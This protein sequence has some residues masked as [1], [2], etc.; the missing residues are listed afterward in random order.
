MKANL[1]NAKLLFVHLGCLYGLGIPIIIVSI[2]MSAWLAINLWDGNWIW[3]LPVLIIISIVFYTSLMIL[4]TYCSK[5]WQSRRPISHKIL[6]WGCIGFMYLASIGLSIVLSTQSIISIFL[7]KSGEID[8][9][10]AQGLIIGS[11][12]WNFTLSLLG[13]LYFW[14]E[15]ARMRL[16][17]DIKSILSFIIGKRGT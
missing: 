17:C 5:F 13:L 12:S 10:N 6:L 3:L 2:A 8:V 16:E 7:A 1:L 4:L 14:A 9:G 15:T 11:L